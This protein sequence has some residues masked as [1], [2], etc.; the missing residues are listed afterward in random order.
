MTDALRPWRVLLLPAGYGNETL[1][2]EALTFIRS[3]GFEAS[4]Y[5]RP[6]YPV[7]S[8]VHSHS[9]CIEAIEQHDIVV[10]IVDEKQGGQFQ[11]DEI[12]AG[13]R[14]RLVQLGVIAASY[15]SRPVPSIL[16]AEVLTAP[17]I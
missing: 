10:A 17:K 14:S 4:V 8:S 2:D 11:V 6:G 7:D 15:E 13:L 12:P 5:D 3:L 1:R 9:A 16:Q